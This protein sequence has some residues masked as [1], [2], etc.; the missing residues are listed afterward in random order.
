MQTDMLRITPVSTYIQTNYCYA[1]HPDPE[2]RTVKEAVGNL[3]CPRRHNLLG[4]DSKV[5]K[6]T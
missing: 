5:S 6:C 2:E 1:H 3:K 4:A